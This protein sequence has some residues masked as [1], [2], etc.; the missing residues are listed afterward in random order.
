M[1]PIPD[2][3]VRS[4]GRVAQIFAIQAGKALPFMLNQTDQNTVTWK[5][6]RELRKC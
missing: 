3:A 1:R 4:D 2:Y 6:P 5:P